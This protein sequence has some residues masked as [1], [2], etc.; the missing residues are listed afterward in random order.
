MLAR[1]WGHAERAISRATLFAAV[2]GKQ[3]QSGMR[4]AP[5]L[6][7]ARPYRERDEP[8]SAGFVDS[9]FASPGKSR[10]EGRAVRG[11][12]A[13]QR[14]AGTE[15]FRAARLLLQRAVSARICE[16]APGAPASGRAA[17]RE[18]GRQARGGVAASRCKEGLAECSVAWQARGP[19][20]GSAIRWERSISRRA[21]CLHQVPAWLPFDQET[22]QVR[23]PRTQR[24]EPRGFRTPLPYSPLSGSPAET[25]SPAAWPRG[26][27]GSP[28]PRCLGAS[29]RVARRREATPVAR[30]PGEAVSS[31][32]SA[33]TRELSASG[34]A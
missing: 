16:R 5:R 25:S 2:R 19:G 31:R 15:Q 23:L 20:S 10:R 26:G 1:V 22:D 24:G 32:G 33:A 3:P 6:S 18:G 7:L 11:G 28:M 27:W 4:W 30:P 12:P 9:L 14:S 8:R 13:W 21:T 34:R 29:E 17:R